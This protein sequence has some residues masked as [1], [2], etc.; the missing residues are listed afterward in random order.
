MI[1]KCLIAAALTVATAMSTTGASANF[2]GV[3]ISSDGGRIA[4]REDD[5]RIVWWNTERGVKTII[6]PKGV[7]W[8]T[9]AAFDPT[10]KS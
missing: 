7:A 2:E 9:S 1:Q 3:Y 10:R 4:T 8:A 6:K 5:R